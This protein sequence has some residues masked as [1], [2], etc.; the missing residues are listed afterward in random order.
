MPVL[1]IRND[2]LVKSVQFKKHKYVGDP[3]NAVKIFNEKEVDEIIILD[4]DASAKKEAPNFK[5]VEKICGESFMP[6]AYGGGV[7]TLEDAQK[8]LYN[9]AEKIVLNTSLLEQPKVIESI[10]KQ[11]GNQSVVASIDYRT[12]LFGKPKVYG[13]NGSKKTKWTALELAKKAA[14]YGAGEIMLNAIDRDGTYKGYDLE[15]LKTVSSS[16]DVP[17]I[18]C[19]GASG[20]EDFEEAIKHGAGAVAAG[21]MFVFQRPHQ[22]VLISYPNSVELNKLNEKL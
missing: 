10:A 8:L 2:G 3:I 14:D 15:T 6:L 20:L 12:S 5:L 11:F 16:V 17:V 22:A 7:K 9:G 19:G 18:A 4:I 1:L 13:F 21:S